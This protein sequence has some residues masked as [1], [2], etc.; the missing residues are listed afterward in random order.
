M[1]VGAVFVGGDGAVAVVEFLVGG[2]L[3]EQ[4]LAA[5]TT[6]M[7]ATIAIAFKSF[8]LRLLLLFS[9]DLGTPRIIRNDTNPRS[10]KATG[11]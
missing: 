4:P 2:W 5:I 10:I 1:P 6:A 11:A 3:F 9:I 7:Q 8:A